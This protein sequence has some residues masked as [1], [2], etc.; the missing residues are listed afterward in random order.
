MPGSAPRLSGP[1]RGSAVRG[2]RSAVV[3]VTMACQSRCTMCDIW[4]YG[5]GS[6]LRPEDYSRL[7]ASLREVNISGGEPFLRKDLPDIVRVIRARCPKA[8]IVI[9]TNALMPARIEQ[10]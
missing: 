4:Q 9:S 6:E 5:R 7:P 2:P 3:A 8:R 10:M 1:R